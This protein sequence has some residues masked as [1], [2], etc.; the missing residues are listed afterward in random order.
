VYAE[1]AGSCKSTL[2]L[3]RSQD[4]M[5][6]VLQAGFSIQLRG[7]NFFLQGAHRKAMTIPGNKGAAVRSQSMSD[8]FMQAKCKSYQDT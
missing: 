7:E 6:K 5:G 3:G 4:S 8:A 1:Q 2:A